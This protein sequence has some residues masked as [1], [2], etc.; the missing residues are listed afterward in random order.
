VIYVSW[1]D[2]ARYCNGLSKAQGLTPAY[3]DK[4][5][6]LAANADGYRLPSE[7]QWEYVATGRGENRTYPW[8]KETPTPQ[9]CNMTLTPT[10]TTLL[11]ARSDPAAGTTVVG[12]YPA[13]ASRD[14]VMDLAGNVCQWC[15]DWLNPYTAADQ[16]DPVSNKTSNFRS[17]RGGSWGYYGGTQRCKAR[18]FNNPNYPGYIY[19]GF[20]V[21]LPEAGYRRIRSR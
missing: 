9:L 16:T 14:G 11:P 17:I 5:W 1:P 3:D 21:V 7:A 19:I 8:G 13:G 15:Q 18:E 12:A 6:E 2:A 10:P 4:N 20:R